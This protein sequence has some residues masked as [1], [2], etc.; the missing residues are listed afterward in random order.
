M[1]LQSQNGGNGDR[2]TPEVHGSASIAYHRLMDSQAS[3]RSYLQQGRWL[4]RNN[5]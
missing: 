3:E 1:P 4:L 2:G 5:G